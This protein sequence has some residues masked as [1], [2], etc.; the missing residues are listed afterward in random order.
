MLAVSL[1]RGGHRHVSPRDGCTYSFPNEYGLIDTE[2]GQ[3]ARPRD[4]DG[5]ERP[6]EHRR[7]FDVTG[8]VGAWLCVSHVLDVVAHDDCNDAAERS[9]YGAFAGCGNPK[10][11]GA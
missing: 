11:T 8:R 1:S 7:H 10:G 6:L 9:A 3:H 2:H 4:D 5:I